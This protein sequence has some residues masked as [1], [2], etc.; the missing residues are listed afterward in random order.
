V[1]KSRK[2]IN[3]G[4]TLYNKI[5]KEFTRINNTLPEDRKLS[6]DER[7][8]YI[9]ENIYP[10]YKG[11]APN[12]VG[13]KKIQGSITQVLETIIPKEGCDVNYISPSTTADIGWF[14]L[15]D[16]IRDVLPKCIYI[17][18]DAN[19]FGTTKIFNTLNY[20]YVKSGVR[21]I[22]EN[23]REFVDNN[24]ARGRSIEVS[25]TGVKKLRKGKAND[26][27]P[28]NYYLDF[29]LTLNSEPIKPLEP[30]IYNLPREER[31]KA[32]SVK[33]AIL[34]RVKELNNKKKRRKNARKK[35]IQNI[36]EVRKINKRMNKAKSP[37]YKRKLALQKIKGFLKAE[38]QIETAYKRGNLTQDQYDKFIAELK[39]S[40]EIAKKQGGII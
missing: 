3:K 1:A 28:E 16:Y 11:I 35:A 24:I 33:N 18:I 26:G 19:G 36:S 4:V 39:R 32:T 21:N 29:I 40:I 2:N 22:V 38:K 13:I 7:R 20:N 30:V 10:Q 5:L 37:D 12:R 17:R 14:E 8:R 34:Q 31:K 23:I 6:L 15:D 9:K 27:T 25:L